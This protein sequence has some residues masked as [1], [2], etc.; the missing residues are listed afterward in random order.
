MISQLY[1]AHQKDGATVGVDIEVGCSVVACGVVWLL[2]A[3]CG[4]FW[5]CVV[6]CGVVWL[7]VAWCSCS[8]GVVGCGVVWPGIVVAWCG[9][10]G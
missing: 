4:C 8:C 1:A 2:V 3:W 7:V 10:W 5:H 6:A 9:W